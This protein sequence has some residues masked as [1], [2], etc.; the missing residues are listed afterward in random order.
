[1]RYPKLHDVEHADQDEPTN[2]ELEG[3]NNP[4]PPGP[5]GPSPR[6]PTQA[7]N[8]PTCPKVKLNPSLLAG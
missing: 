2:D 8:G 7:L 3:P 4:D 6:V 1:M 5:I